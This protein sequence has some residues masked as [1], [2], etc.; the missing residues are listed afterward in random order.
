M[1]ADWHVVPTD[2]AVID[3]FPVGNETDYAGED[4]PEAM[5][6]ITVS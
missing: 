3:G 5:I 6:Q 2:L 1:G 4:D